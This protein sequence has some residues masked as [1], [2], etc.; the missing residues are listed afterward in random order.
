LITKNNTIESQLLFPVLQYLKKYMPFPTKQSLYMSVFYP[1]ARNW[2]P[3]KEFPDNVK[4]VNP[5]I[6][7]VQSYIDKIERK[8]NNLPYSIIAIAAIGLYLLMKG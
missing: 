1:A 8:T 6:T 5:G 2:L 4:K 3:G 7:T